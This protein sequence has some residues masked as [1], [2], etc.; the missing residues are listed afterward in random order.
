MILQSPVKPKGSP[1]KAGAAAT[2]TVSNHHGQNDA[3][4]AVVFGFRAFGGFRL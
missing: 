4:P 2:V 3:A 1:S